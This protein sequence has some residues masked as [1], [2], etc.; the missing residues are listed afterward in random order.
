MRISDRRVENP[1]SSGRRFLSYGRRLFPLGM[2][3]A[4][5]VV[6]FGQGGCHSLPRC[7]SNGGV[8]NLDIENGPCSA[9]IDYSRDM[10]RNDGSRVC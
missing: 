10:G 9:L 6:E 4:C 1:Q 8:Y 3:L 5:V 7:N 2:A